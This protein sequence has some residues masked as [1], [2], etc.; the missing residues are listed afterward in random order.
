[1]A[2]IL[3]KPSAQ[4]EL[5]TYET[6]ISRKNNK[7]II[8]NIATTRLDFSHLTGEKTSL[9]SQIA[10]LQSRIDEIDEMLALEES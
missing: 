1:M 7:I 6:S 9:Q 5:T 3:D 10:A 2:K 4:R 8:K